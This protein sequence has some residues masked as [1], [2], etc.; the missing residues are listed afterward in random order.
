MTDNPR[1]SRL[2]NELVLFS[3]FLLGG[4]LLLP[5]AIYL[6]GNLVFGDYEGGYGQFFGGISRGILGF[7]IETWFLILS[8]YL[9]LQVLRLTLTL[10]RKTAST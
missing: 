8:P 5:L 7:D 10:F 9:A 4:F 6:T 3:A 1:K 2:V